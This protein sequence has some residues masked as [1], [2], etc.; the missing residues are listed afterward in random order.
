MLSTRKTLFLGN[1]LLIA[2]IICGCIEL[3]IA[4]DS[5]L[6]IDLPNTGLSNTECRKIEETFRRIDVDGDGKISR[7][8]VKG[9]GAKFADQE[10]FSQGEEEAVIQSFDDLFSFYASVVGT[11]GDVLTKEMVANCKNTD[12][13]QDDRTQCKNRIGA[14]LYSL[15]SPM[16]VVKIGYL[17]FNEFNRIFQS[18]GFS[19]ATLTRLAFTAIDTDFNGEVTD[20]EFYASTTKY[21]CTDDPVF[22]SLLG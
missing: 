16:K 18:L 22:P 5:F 15:V 19:D 2:A 1:L 6:G 10:G 20:Q 8:D 12:V 21:M 11:T 3:S 13:S 17:N 4:G 9:I 7:S 14:V